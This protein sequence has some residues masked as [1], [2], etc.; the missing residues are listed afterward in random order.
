MPKTRNKKLDFS[1]LV[2]LYFAHTDRKGG[3]E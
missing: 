2:E 3:I 1:L